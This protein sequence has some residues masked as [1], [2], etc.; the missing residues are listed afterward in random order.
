MHKN[1]TPAQ[2]ANGNTQILLLLL[3]PERIILFGFCRILIGIGE[4]GSLLLVIG[5]RFFKA[6]IVV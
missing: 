3:L 4:A 2:G 5:I 1:L 6:F